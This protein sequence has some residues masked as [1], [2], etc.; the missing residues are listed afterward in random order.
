MSTVSPTVP[1]LPAHGVADRVEFRQVDGDV[2][3]PFDD[4]TF[5]VVICNDAFNHLPNRPE[6]LR[7]W[8][9]VLKPG[10]RAMFTDPVVV[11][12]LVS[13]EEL[14]V[15]SSVGF[16][17]FGPPG[18]NE[19]LIADAGLELVKRDDVTE[20]TAAIAGRWHAARADDEEALVKVEGE[21]RFKGL[22][23]FL[24]TVHKLASERRLSRIAYLVR[25]PG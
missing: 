14:A 23:D 21:E 15:R 18:V 20:N 17:L 24:S 2:C 4:G 3:L 16:F 8:C 22:Q 25:N 12:G 5:D 11:T 1:S 19:Q 10:G 6:V 13:N 9:R 7:E